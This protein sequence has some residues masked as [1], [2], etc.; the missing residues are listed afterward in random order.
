L[1]RRESFLVQ[2]L[3]KCGSSIKNKL[4]KSMKCPGCSADFPLTWRRYLTAPFGK[5]PCPCC[6]AGLAGRHHWWYWPLL[7]LGCCIFGVPFAYVAGTHFGWQSGIAA[8]IVGGLI[9]G[10]P[11]DKYLESRFAILIVQQVGPANG[12]EAIRSETNSTSSAA[13]SRR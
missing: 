5:F 6:K 12:S 3:R 1:S 7:V 2:D 10:I 8:W 13:G 9:S 4:D 11:F